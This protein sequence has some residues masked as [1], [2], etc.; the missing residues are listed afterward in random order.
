MR[1]RLPSRTER[2]SPA[3][4]LFNYF[5]SP[6]IVHPGKLSDRLSPPSA[7]RRKGVF[8]RGR[9][10]GRGRSSRDARWLESLRKRSVRSGH[11][12]IG[13]PER[14]EWKC[15]FKNELDGSETADTPLPPQ[16]RRYPTGRPEGGQPR[17]RWSFGL[18]P[19]PCLGPRVGD[20]PWQPLSRRPLLARRGDPSRLRD[21]FPG[22]FGVRTGHGCASATRVPV[23]TITPPASLTPFLK[24]TSTPPAGP[25]ARRPPAGHAESDRSRT[26]STVRI[27]TRPASA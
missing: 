8:G 19:F 17:M 16:R 13:M 18:E 27:R 11:G 7:F 1:A 6:R 12:R 9:R 10:H 25:R 22:P 2:V 23:T 14:T 3:H 24:R 5:G 20:R 21:G 26:P 4:P 15:P